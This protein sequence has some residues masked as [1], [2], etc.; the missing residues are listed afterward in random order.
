MEEITL[1]CVMI[2]V[3]CIQMYK[4]RT[5]LTVAALFGGDLYGYTLSRDVM[6]TEVSSFFCCCSFN[7]CCLGVLLELVVLVSR[8][9]RRAEE[10]VYRICI[11]L[12][13]FSNDYFTVLFLLMCR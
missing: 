3:R 13:L 6:S 11:T 12:Q 8:I 10:L 9:N 4:D 5:Y 2:V 1:H 7:D